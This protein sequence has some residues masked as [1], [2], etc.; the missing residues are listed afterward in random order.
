MTDEMKDTPVNTPAWIAPQVTPASEPPKSKRA[1]RTKAQMAEAN[2]ARTDGAA[3][4]SEGVKDLASS[5]EKKTDL[6]LGGWVPFVVAIL[7]LAVAILK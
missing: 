4:L 5:P 7:A 3:I 2:A 1:R 6:L